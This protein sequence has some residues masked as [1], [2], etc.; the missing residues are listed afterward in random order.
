MYVRTY[1]CMYVCMYV[2]MCMCIKAHSDTHGVCPRDPVGVCVLSLWLGFAFP[3]GGAVR[4]SGFWLWGSL[5]RAAMDS[6]TSSRNK[7][8]TGQG[9]RLCSCAIWILCLSFVN[10][11]LPQQGR[12]ATTIASGRTAVPAGL[13]YRSYA[14]QYSADALS[15]IFTSGY[16]W[17]G[18]PH[19]LSH[20]RIT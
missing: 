12:P 5:P 3:F 7:I 4:C 18:S 1:V 8:R 10:S 15:A 2:R 14:K 16:T 11:G 9:L 6:T 20:S 13:S 19:R 17:S